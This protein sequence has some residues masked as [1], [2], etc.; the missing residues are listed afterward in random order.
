[1]Y[2]F[3]SKDMSKRNKKT[4]INNDEAPTIIDKVSG[5]FKNTID[6]FEKDRFNLITAFIFLVVIGIVRSVSESLIYEYQIFSFYLV[7]QHTAFNFPVLV[8]GSLIISIASDT[9]LRKVYNTILPGFA[10]VL[11][12]P[13]V[14]YFMLGFGGAEFSELYA[15]YAA[16][17][18][19]IDK[20]QDLNPIN[21]LM[22]PEISTGLKFM[23]VSILILTGLY[24]SVKVR[25][26]ESIKKVTDGIYRPFLR[27]LCSLF[28]GVYGIV[29]VIWFISSI[30]PSIITFTDSVVIFDY[31]SIEPKYTH[32]LFIG[33][34]GY[35]E[36]EI[37][38][39]AA[40]MGLAG[41]LALQQR[42][43]YITMFFVILTVSIVLLSLYI[44]HR[45]LLKKIFGSLRS[46][47]IMVT[48]LS[49]LLGSAVLHITDPDFL[50]GWALD[51]NYILHIPYLFY[52]AGTGFL[53]GCMGSFVLEYYRDEPKLPKWVSKNMAIVSLIAGGSFAFIMCPGIKFGIFLFSAIL[54]Y[55]AF[56]KGSLRLRPPEAFAFASA[57]LLIYFTGLLSPSIW[58]IRSGGMTI[59]LPR[60]PQ[61]GG[62]V[63]LLGTVIFLTVLMVQLFPLLPEKD[64]F[65]AKWK[66]GTIAL[67]IVILPVV[68]LRGTLDILVFG[69]LG[70]SAMMLTDE[71][72]TMIPKVVS[73]LGML[74]I[75]FRLWDFFTIL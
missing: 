22:A 42:S 11:L 28:F 9:P 63:L 44:K 72:L 26:I 75:L 17:E 27:N 6:F 73:A 12:P 60:T 48:T 52:I 16:G 35:I 67:L 65:K 68:M 45:T 21:M 15:Y 56:R 14:D 36:N 71:D 31:I 24:I 61:I 7:V 53:L 2:D 4:E 62:P 1:M 20:F 74:Y 64:I 34:Y 23:A 5:L 43:L 66:L 47:L 70:A 57:C 59:D 58:K 54:I 8:M 32:Y 33:Q 37:F 29:V 40:E 10:I 49:A 55:I 69:A 30:V 39:T 46:S 50:K 13:F 25:L 38:G 41:Q 18:L 3:T 51:P 19:F